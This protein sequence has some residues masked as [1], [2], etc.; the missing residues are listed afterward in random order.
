MRFRK[1]KRKKNDI[2]FEFSLQ[3]EKNVLNLQ[4]NNNYCY[5]TTSKK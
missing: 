5:Y 3:Y 2:F 1:K 4:R